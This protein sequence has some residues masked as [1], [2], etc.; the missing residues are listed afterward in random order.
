MPPKISFAKKSITCVL[1]GLVIGAA[2]FRQG[3][4]YFRSWVPQRV[5]VLVPFFFVAVA[6]IYVIFWQARK[7]D[8]PATLAFWQGLIRYG[9]AFDLAEFGWS[10]ICHLQLVLPASKLDLPYRSFSSSELFWYFY[11]HSYPLACIIA[12]LQITGALLLLFH[13]T[14]LTGVFVLLPVL[15]NIVLMDIFYSIGDS[16]V[17]HASIMMAGVLYFLFIEFQRLKEFFFHAKDRLPSVHL[18]SWVK[19]A[20][21]LSVIYVPL[22]LI[23][24]HG[25]PDRYPE[26]TGKYEVQPVRLDQR[27]LYKT[28]CADSVLSTVYFDVRNGCVFEFNSPERRWN[29]NFTRDNE[30][31]GDVSPKSFRFRIDWRSPVDKPV[32]NGLLSQTDGSGRWALRGTL[33]KDSLDI[34]LQKVDRR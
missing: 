21:R 18:P 23:A 22:L 25:R 3:I 7:T 19:M 4:T 34:I 30:S 5:L 32:F 15:A 6:V 11:S 17:V 1:A 2:V 26:L 10:K 28:G 29:G 33:G 13:K 14:R 12:G 31:S 20:I 8:R 24:L 16:S 27:A 9:V